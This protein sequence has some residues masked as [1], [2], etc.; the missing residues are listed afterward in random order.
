[1]IRILLLSLLL[2]SQAVAGEAVIHPGDTV[3]LRAAVPQEEAFI[4]N[5]YPVDD[6]GKIVL[7]F[8][9]KVT[10]GGLTAFEAAHVID[11]SYLSRQVFSHPAATISIGGPDPFVVVDGQIG[12]PMHVA[13]RPEL[14]LL[15]ALTEAGGFTAAADQKAVRLE[16]MT[17]GGVAVCNVSKIIQH[18]E[19]DILLR[20]GDKVHVEVQQP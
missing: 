20:A 16:R 10:I 17:R 1:M 6:F 11:E 2:R 18:P 3:L 8:V 15:Q 5:F 7:P 19:M 13:I 14:T 4:N 9:G 12:H